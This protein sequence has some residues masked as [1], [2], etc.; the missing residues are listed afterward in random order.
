MHHEKLMK[1][2]LVKDFRSFY[3]DIVRL[4][5][6]ALSGELL[7]NNN[8][9][10]EDEKAEPTTLCQQIQKHLLDFLTAQHDYIERHGGGFAL[11]YYKEA[12]YIMVALADE[13]FLNME[14]VGREEWKDN[15]LESQIFNTQ[16][17]GETFF[18]NLDQFL[19]VRDSQNSDIGVLYIFALGLGFKGRYKDVEDQSDLKRYRDHLQV[20]VM[21]GDP[22]S[23]QD[24]QQLFPEAYAH[25]IDSRDGIRVPTAQRWL[26][27]LGGVFGGYLILAYLIWAINVGELES[28]IEQIMQWVKVQ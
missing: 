28:L 22:Y 12:Q 2:L 27:I 16:V 17:A 7:A 24:A 20:R 9:H 13:T 25:T 5:A 14:W 26:M 19:E 23:S 6:K 18:E 3:E 11:K 4:K 8:E 10:E 15:L 21:H 1:S